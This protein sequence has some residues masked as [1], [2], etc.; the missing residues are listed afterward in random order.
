MTEDSGGRSTRDSAM[1]H[2]RGLLRRQSVA[3][4]A[5]FLSV[6]TLFS[7][8]IGFARD[9]IVAHN[10][11]ATGLTDAFLIGMMV[12]SVLLGIVSTGLS[13]IIV[14]WYIAHRKDD[15]A[16]ARE[17]VNQ[18]TFV[19]GMAFLAAS[20]L[21]VAFAP[22]L[23]HLFAPSF[24]D[25][26]YDVAVKVTR[27]LVP[28]GFFNVM[29]GLVTGLSQAEGQF[30][31]PLL[32]NVF[33]NVLM[34][35]CLI[36]FATPLGIQSY[37]LGQTVMSVIG[38]AP[39]LW[40]LVRRRGF[41][42]HLDMRH[43]DWRAI[44][45][46][47]ALLVPLVISGGGGSMNTV[48]DRWFASH[49]SQGSGSA[50]DYSNRLWNLPLA[51]AATPIVTAV[52]PWFSSMAVD[53]TLLATFED[54]V[55]KTVGLMIYIM[56]PC[57]AGLVVLAQ[58]IVRLLFERGAFDASATSLT[59]ACVQMYCLGLIGQALFPVFHRVFYSFKDTRTPLVVG[60]VMIAINAV[61]DWLFGM[62]FG[63]AGIAL[64]T[65]AAVTV[66][67]I[68]DAL[69]IRRFFRGEVRT[70]IRYPLLRESLKTLAAVIPVV[71][72][73]LLCR[74]W[75][76]AAQGFAHLALRLVLVCLAAAVCYMISSVALHIDGWRILLGRI[77]RRVTRGNEALSTDTQD[78]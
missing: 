8:F 48:V 52:F 1:S 18:V 6:V 65:T 60:V 11:G 75:I 10:W 22:Q 12:P 26:R 7:K 14:P 63:A 76:G 42:R 24:T 19:W 58:P 69:L 47:A 43:V 61:T 23:V 77:R 13:T 15:P 30:L 5:V 78:L 40:F 29:T 20:L 33:G 9:A 41:F 38:F 55:R 25:F 46:F 59:A 32:S 73:A 57:I 35:G 66:G 51:L 36:F 53:G 39:V 64:S 68:M 67:A 70:T 17:L 34:V 37:S 4:A 54:R 49:L 74:A 72:V 50:L 16:R 44:G 28:M 31:I 45:S 3:Q 21:V 71:G 56:V 62:W 27:L 2:G